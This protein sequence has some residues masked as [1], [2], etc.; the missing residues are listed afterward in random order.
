[1]RPRSVW[2]AAA[3]LGTIL[4]LA[5]GVAYAG[6][7]GE[8]V[9]LIVDPSKPESLYV[10]NHYKAA[11]NIP[12]QNVLYMDP[13]A[14]DYATFASVNLD[15]LFG[16]LAN[17]GVLDHIDYIVIPPGGS[18]YVTAPGYVVDGCSAVSRFSVSGAYALAFI[19][20]EILAG[21]VQVSLTNHYYIN[22]DVARAFDSSIGWLNGTPSSMTGNRRYFIG[23]MLGYTGERGNTVPEIIDMI[24]RSVAVDG[25]RPAGTYYYEQTTDVAR[26]NPRH[27]N[28]PTAV[29]SIEA[30]GGQAEH[31]MAILPTGRHDCLGIMTGWASPGIE[32]TD[33]TILP[34]SF[35]DHLTSYAATFDISS[36]EKISL[37]VRRG[38]SG[39]WG[40]VQEPCN[41]AGKFPHARMHVFYH[42]GLSLGE[43]V[44][45]SVNYAPFQGL[46]LGDPLTRPFAYVPTIEVPDA[47]V[48]P[49]S[50]EILINP[51]GD[52]PHP[53]AVIYRFDVLIDGVFR[54]A[55]LPDT[56]IPID[57]AALADGWHELRVLG[58]D[59]TLVRSTGAWVGPL[60]VNNR[61]RFATLSVNQSSG[62][63]STPF[64]FDVA[65]AGGVIREMRV[66]HNGRV[67]AAGAGSSQALLVFGATL[68]AGDVRVQ[69]EALFADGMLVRS[70][71][72]TLSIAY[73]AG[74]PAAAP[75]VAYGYTKRVLD[76]QPFVIELPA[77]FDN[78]QTALTYEIVTP[79]TEASLTAGQTGPS[80]LMRPTAN[81]AGVDTF[82]YRVTS[83]AGNSSTA[84]V[85]IVFGTIDGDL[86]CD[87]A[88]NNFDIDPFVLAVTNPAGYNA[89][90]PLCNVNLADMNRDG[91]IDNFDIDP[92]VAAVAGI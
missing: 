38:A 43:A 91:R 51:T 7:S 61:G 56:E 90:Y 16:W 32:T 49:V 69:A 48:G 8:N 46:L 76:D 55:V 13:G 57:T 33:M 62:D 86:N 2:N 22:S 24:D 54:T 82:T 15:A 4:G 31:Q 12:D 18:F 59:S 27:G 11:R 75:P 80:R 6:G 39:S 45:R 20:N 88:L 19:E 1:M 37:W 5:A 40:Q 64:V 34:G 14:P 73:S 85:R 53:T 52:S 89:A 60:N 26:S 83:A 87:G 66:L 68:G 58:I 36:Q 84:M 21:N 74:A 44:Q 47:P 17:T 10:A 63:L 79:P 9:L 65:G 72:R 77:T 41:Y 78:N 70:A 29:A 81:A 71:P 25:T 67:V 23:A 30:L 92:F 42:Q 28:Y 3:F 35:C 50:G